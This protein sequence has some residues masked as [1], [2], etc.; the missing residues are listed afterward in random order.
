MFVEAVFVE[1]VFVEEL[2]VKRVF[3]CGT[4]GVMDVGRMD[5]DGIEVEYDP[6]ESRVRDSRGRSF[7][8]CEAAA[9]VFVAGGVHLKGMKYTSPVLRSGISGRVLAGGKGGVE[10]RRSARKAQLLA[11]LYREAGGGYRRGRSKRQ[12]AL[13]KRTRVFVA[14]AGKARETGRGVRGGRGGEGEGDVTG[15]GGGRREP[16]VGDRKPQRPTGNRY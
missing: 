5:I 6:L 14:N 16:I 9:E 3:V 7:V 10:G 1:D 13:L 4:M 8:W 12:G 2:L 11:Q 15:V